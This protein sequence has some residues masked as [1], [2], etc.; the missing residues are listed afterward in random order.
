MSL[1]GDYYLREPALPPLKATHI[2]EYWTASNGVFIRAQ[3]LG[4]EA[5]IPVVLTPIPIAGLHPIRPAIHLEYPPVSQAMVLD[6]LAASFEAREHVTQ[7]LQ[8]ILFYL[9]WTDGA[10]H[11]TKPDQERT[12][13]RV[14]PTDVYD[15]STLPVPVLDLHSHHTMRPFFSST[16]TED[17]HGFRINAVWGYLDRVPTILVRLGVYGH[18]YPIPAARVFDLPSFIQ[19]GYAHSRAHQEEWES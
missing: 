14:T 11:W 4:V 12:A 2:M 9:R 6:L 5:L 8:E 17:D 13:T 7:A 15:T 1:F 10:W 16:D 18:Y 3:R 19:D